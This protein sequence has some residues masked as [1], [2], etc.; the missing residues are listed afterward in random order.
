[1]PN[2]YGLTPSTVNI[3]TFILLKQ[4]K[5]TLLAYW[6]TKWKQSELLSNRNYENPHVL[7]C[8]LSFGEK[9]MN[10]V[11]KSSIERLTDRVKQWNWRSRN[12]GGAKMIGVDT[13]KISFWCSLVAQ[14]QTWPTFFLQKSMYSRF[15]PSMEGDKELLEKSRHA[16]NGLFNV[17]TRKVV[18][19]QTFTLYSPYFCKSIVRNIAG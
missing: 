14:C 7:E 15:Y 10:Q 13:T 1:M 8:T 4:N 16:V 17:L 18:V 3:L 12:R 19:N 6:K 11:Q 5:M 9:I 2:F